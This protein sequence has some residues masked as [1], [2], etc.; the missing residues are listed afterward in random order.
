MLCTA[1]I[2]DF[3]QVSG[4][5]TFTADKIAFISNQHKMNQVFWFLAMFIL[6]NEKVF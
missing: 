3:S 4:T 1:L 2:V 6:R 5:T